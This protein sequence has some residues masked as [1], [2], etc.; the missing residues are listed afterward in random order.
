MCG[1]AG[2]IWDDPHLSLDEPQLRRMT[3]ALAHRGPDDEGT[4]RSGYLLRPPYDPVP[5]VA[6]ARGGCRSST[7]KGAISPSRTRTVPFGSC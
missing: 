1:I 5:G 2:G 3:D 4:Y 7:W 6:L